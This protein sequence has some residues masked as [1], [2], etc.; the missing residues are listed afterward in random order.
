MK[1]AQ[2]PSALDACAWREDQGR[3]GGTI[4][5]RLFLAPKYC[6][7]GY[8]VGQRRFGYTQG[9]DVVSPLLRRRYSRQTRTVS[10]WFTRDGSLFYHAKRPQTGSR[11]SEETSPLDLMKCDTSSTA[12]ALFCTL[13]HA[14]V[15]LVMPMGV[16]STCSWSGLSWCNQTT[17]VLHPNGIPTLDRDERDMHSLLRSPSTPRT[18]PPCATVFQIVTKQRFWIDALENAG[19]CLE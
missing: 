4:G 19:K 16:S 6:P 7:R 8:Y 3:P 17:P 13:R 12:C 1:V 5:V 9:H 2:S 14:S 18:P 15:T 11:M 10:T